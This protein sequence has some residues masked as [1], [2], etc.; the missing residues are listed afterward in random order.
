MSDWSQIT[1]VARREFTERARSR[2]FRSSIVVLFL[3]VVGAFF[4]ASFFLGES[5]ATEL[6]VGGESPAGLADDIR[7][8]ASVAEIDVA[9]TVFA[10]GAEATNAVEDGDV[11]AALIEGNTIV[12]VSEPSATVQGILATAANVAA[13]RVAAAGLNL[14]EADVASIVVPVDVTV[15]ELEP[16]EPEDPEN[17]AR[18]VVSFF[19][20]IVLLTTIMMFGQFVAMG[21]VE[22]K[23][24]R[25]VEVILSRIKTSSLLIGKVLGIGA[26]GLVQVAALGLA[27]VVGLKLSPLPDF[28][29]VDLGSLGTSAVFWVLFWFTLGYLMYSF[30]YATLG[31]TISRQEDMQSV[32]FIPALAILPAYF[33][34]V[35]SV[36]DGANAAVR[37]A[38]FVP[39][40][41]PI[42]MPF[43][44]NIGD[45]QPWEV[46]VS[47]VLIIAAIAAL[48]G[49]GSRVYRG[50]A[51]RTGGRVSLL[52]AWKSGQG[53]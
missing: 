47:V 6:G 17:V 49:I 15:V 10:S 53:E 36:E 1:T 8:S 16:S 21:I 41:S 25:I 37:I 12:S 51:L 44:V 29:G 48:V 52:D 3:L 4:V 13:R 9:V 39:M 20:A 38:S 22:E 32:A 24:N 42:I 34:M 31:A 2:V 33:L 19:A 40:W 50:A 28:D 35:F 30:L 46:A 43:R 26:L 7:S 11:E 23:Q 45:A 27:V 5:E 18:S 14:T